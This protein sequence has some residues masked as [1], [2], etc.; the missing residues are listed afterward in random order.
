MA[1]GVDP[2]V[3]IGGQHGGSWVMC[4]GETK[5]L[6]EGFGFIVEPAVHGTGAR[7]RLMG[8]LTSRVGVGI[9]GCLHKDRGNYLVFG[10]GCV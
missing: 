7:G 10:C 4:D 2:L 5:L 9:K 3:E 6:V 1:H 8:V